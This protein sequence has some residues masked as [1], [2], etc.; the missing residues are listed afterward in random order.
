MTVENDLLKRAKENLKEYRR[1][2]KERR[3]ANRPTK[4]EREKASK[5]NT[6]LFIKRTL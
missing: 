2:E 4:K 5:K 3:Q 6:A 1:K